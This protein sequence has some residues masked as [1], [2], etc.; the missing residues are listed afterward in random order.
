MKKELEML[1]ERMDGFSNPKLQLEQYVTPPA[2]AAEMAVNAKLMGDLQNVIDLGCG[3]GILAI[4]AA[5]LGA[6]ATGFDVDA[7]ALRIAKRNARSMGVHVDFVQSDVRRFCLKVDE[8]SDVTTLMNPPFGIQVRHAD[9]PFLEKAME[10]SKVIYSIHSA[11]SQE[12]VS[13][14]AEQRGFVIT[15]LWKYSIPLRRT[16]SFHEKAF[17]Y[18]PVEVFRLERKKDEVR[19]ARR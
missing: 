17:K 16:Y 6:E 2:L 4:A 8:L 10:F 12:F 14:M 5:L 15:H 11:G 19:N 7:G 3:T 9:R 1:L 18:I 13:R